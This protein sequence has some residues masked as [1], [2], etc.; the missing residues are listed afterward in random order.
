MF[1]ADAVS[2][3]DHHIGGISDFLQGVDRVMT[4]LSIICIGGCSLTDSVYFIS[5][6]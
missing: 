1:L 2:I 4:G 6:G 3:W 5:V